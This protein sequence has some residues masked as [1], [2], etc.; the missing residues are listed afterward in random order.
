MNGKMARRTTISWGKLTVLALLLGGCGSEDQQVEVADPDAGAGSGG[1][2]GAT[3]GTGGATGGT[4]GAT[5]GTGGAT[6]GTGGATGGTGGATGGTGGAT[7]GTGGATGGT[8]GATGGT[9]G[10]G[11]CTPASKQ[12]SGLVVQTCDGSG[13]WQNGAPCAYVCVSGSCTGVCTPSAKKCAGLVPETCDTNGNWVSGSVCSY[14]CINGACTG[15]CAPNATQCSG[16]GVQT[17]SS[18]GQ[19]GTV[20]ACPFVCSSGACAGVCTPGAT[21]CSGNGVQTCSSSGQWGTAAAC[22]NQVCVGGACTGVCAPNATQCSGN[23]VQTC[24]SSGQWGTAA[25]CSG[26]TPFCYPVACTATPPSCQG[27]TSNCGPS[28]NESCCTSPV[29]AGGTFNRSNDASYPATVSNFRLDKHEVTVGRFRKFV[30]AAVGGWKPAAGSGKHTHL[31]GGSGLAA[32]GGGNEPGW[33]TTWNTE[34]HT[35]QATWDGASSLN[36]SAV[37]STWTPS[38]GSNETRPINCV[39]WF[40]SAAFCTWDGGFLP[41]EAE[42]NYAAAGGSEQRAYPWGATAPGANANLAVYGCYY[43]GT[44]SCNGFTNIAP[45]G[46]VA[47]GNG[48][49]GQADLGGNMWEW[50]LDWHSSSYVNPCNNCSQLGAASYRVRRG[51]SFNDSASYLLTSSRSNISPSDRVNDV[52]LRCARTP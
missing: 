28:G 34:L 21:Q 23:G 14:A 8:G 16:N 15:V 2:G 19:W 4:G 40:Q 39:N 9:G 32:T 3:G 46:S 50:N 12:C 5:G 45:V 44:G 36:C 13:Q 25:A 31:N 51:G 11:V 18:S 35:S 29:V 37:Y 1:T 41:S 6:G 24:S 30:A 20:A 10:A 48:K 49:W 38:A 7:G 22:T 17:C 52:G 27:L 43:N 42:W 26:A 47:A 33:D